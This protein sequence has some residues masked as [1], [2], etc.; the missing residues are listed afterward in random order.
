MPPKKPKA[1]KAEKKTADPGKK[2]GGS[3]KPKSN[4]AN[5]GDNAEASG[6]SKVAYPSFPAL[7]ILLHY[8]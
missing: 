3:K 5:G 1:Q 2:A 7:Q 8:R 6:S 4:Q